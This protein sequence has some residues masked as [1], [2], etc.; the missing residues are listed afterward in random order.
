MVTNYCTGEWIDEWTFGRGRLNRLCGGGEMVTKSASSG[1]HAMRLFFGNLVV[2][3][4]IGKNSRDSTG[5]YAAW[6]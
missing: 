4:F 3:M 1:L 5:C 6:R 2:Y